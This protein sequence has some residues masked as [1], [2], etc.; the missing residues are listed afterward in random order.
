MQKH[1]PRPRTQHVNIPRTYGAIPIR[2]YTTCALWPTKYRCSYIAHR[3][4]DFSTVSAIWVACPMNI[5]Q[6]AS[7][8]TATLNRSSTSSSSSKLIQRTSL[9]LR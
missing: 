7:L 2:T 1:P 3:V 9:G 8:P 4:V 5:G 6:P